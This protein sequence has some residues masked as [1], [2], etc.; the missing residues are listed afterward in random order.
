MVSHRQIVIGKILACQVT[1]WN[2][3]M[4]CCE[5]AVNNLLKNQQKRLIFEETTKLLFQYCMVNAL[6]IFANIQL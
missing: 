1:N 6:K 4:L 3:F 2:T 5:V